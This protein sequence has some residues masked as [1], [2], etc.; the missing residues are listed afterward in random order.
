MN[1]QI[2][3]ALRA[4]PKRIPPHRDSAT[5]NASIVLYEGPLEIERGGNK[6]ICPGTLL[7]RWLPGPALRFR[8][9]LSDFALVGQVTIRIPSQAFEASGFILHGDGSEASGVL[10]GQ[11]RIGQSGS[12]DSIDFQLTNFH[13]IVGEAI[14]TGTDEYPGGASRRLTLHHT[15]YRVIVD[16]V[17]DYSSRVK[18]VK[19][20]GGFVVSHAGTVTKASGDPIS[21]PQADQ[22]LEA[23]HFFF[24]F[25]RGRW[26]AATFPRGRTANTIIWE[27]V[28]A[29]RVDEWKG[30]LS[31]FP[32]RQA[33]IGGSAW[34]GFLDRWMDPELQPPLKLAIHWY[35]EANTNAGGVEGAVVLAQAALELLA[36]T[37][38]VEERGLMN[39]KEFKKGVPTAEKIRM[40]LQELKIPAD[41]PVELSD[42]RDAAHHLKIPSDPEIFVRLRNGIVHSNK[43]KRADIAHIV[44]AAR[45][46]ALQYGLWCIEMVILRLCNY[47][48][49]YS[50][51]LRHKWVGEVETVPWVN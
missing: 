15:E 8:I 12:V 14:Q 48:G 32:V 19:L 51:R 39:A 11:P 17:D 20:D 25:A 28:G 9:E 13:E 33:S 18:Q 10:N 1:S 6:E 49:V 30:V 27:Q 43:S 29:W 34:T 4:L 21:I 5:P 36:W 31:W 26:C 44:D 42:L 3:D 37:V 38:V 22:V 24:S 40:L 2:L 45:W 23:L 41:V 35:I 16:Q 7:F 50:D 47:K 46:Q